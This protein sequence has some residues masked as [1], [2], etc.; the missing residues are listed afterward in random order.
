MEKANV[1]TVNIP[2]QNSFSVYDVV[3]V[4]E[5]ECYVE[6]AFTKLS[7]SAQDMR[8]LAFIA[9]NISKT[10]GTDGSKPCLYPD[11]DSR[12]K[13]AMSIHLDQGIR[14]RSGLNLKEAVVRQVIA[15]E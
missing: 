6:V 12:E 7:D 11:A 1:A 10:V 8:G 2:D 3:Y 5:P 9:G 4:F 13:G 14:S 15:D